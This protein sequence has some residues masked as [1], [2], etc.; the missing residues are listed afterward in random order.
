MLPPAAADGGSDYFSVE[1]PEG[2]EPGGEVEVNILWD[3]SI[4]A[5]PASFKFA[6]EEAQPEPEPEG[7]RPVRV[8]GGHNIILHLHFLCIWGFSM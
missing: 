6:E 5:Q 8:Q 7:M 2:V 3:G 1:V 4:I